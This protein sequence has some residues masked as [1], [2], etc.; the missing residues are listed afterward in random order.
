MAVPDTEPL[1]SLLFVPSHV[2]SHFKWK[3]GENTKIGW[4]LKHISPLRIFWPII[5][6]F[7]H[8]E[9][10]CSCRALGRSQ[11][12]QN[13]PTLKMIKTPEVI[14]STIL[15][16]QFWPLSILSRASASQ[17]AND[18][19]TLAWPPAPGKLPYPLTALSVRSF[20]PLCLAHACLLLAFWPYS[21][22]NRGR[23][24]TVYPLS[25]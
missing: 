20:S 21:W 24:H 13:Q 3:V 18:S 9:S 5:S 10:N 7:I 25:V 1:P 15:A 23:F 12:S 14:V 22:A 19:S 2:S 8:P 6:C 17:L 16:T 11:R 4:F